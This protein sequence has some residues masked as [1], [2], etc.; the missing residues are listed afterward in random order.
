VNNSLIWVS[1]TGTV[2]LLAVVQAKLP[3]ASL[4]LDQ[5]LDNFT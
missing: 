4:V 2:L 3:N 5:G 1:K